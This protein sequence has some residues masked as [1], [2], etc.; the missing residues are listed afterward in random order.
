MRYADD[1]LIF[2]RS[3]A[4]AVQALKHIAPFI[5]GDLRLRINDD[6]TFIA[7]AEDVKFLGYGFFMSHDG[8]RICVH[9]DSLLKLKER[10]IDLARHIDNAQ[11]LKEFRTYVTSWITHYRLADI[12]KLLYDCSEWLGE[13]VLTTFAQIWHEQQNKL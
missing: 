11:G 13:S 12:E 4:S 6:K 2:C 9:E 5:E 1:M 7:Y 10:L 3:K 8:F